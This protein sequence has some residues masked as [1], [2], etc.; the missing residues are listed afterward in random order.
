MPRRCTCGTRGT[1]R[2]GPSLVLTQTR[3]RL[4]L[5]IS[6]RG[7]ESNSCDGKATTSCPPGYTCGSMVFSTGARAS[8]MPASRLAGTPDSYGSVAGALARSSGCPR[9][10]TGG[11]ES[12]RDRNPRRSSAARESISQG[13]RSEPIQPVV[14]VVQRPNQPRT[15]ASFL[16]PA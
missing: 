5:A 9:T 3:S 13:S 10:R 8:Q 15:R 1:T 12:G 11:N 7:S 4:P 2:C 6:R 16:R 14:S